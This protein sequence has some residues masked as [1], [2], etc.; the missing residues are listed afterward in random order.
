[1]ET[2]NIL[3]LLQATDYLRILKAST[4]FEPSRIRRGERSGSHV[5]FD[6]L[7]NKIGLDGIQRIMGEEWLDKADNIFTSWSI[8]DAE[9]FLNTL[10][11]Q[12]IPIYNIVT[13]LRITVNY[14]H[15]LKNNEINIVLEEMTSESQAESHQ[16]NEEATVEPSAEVSQVDEQIGSQIE[17]PQ[18]NENEELIETSPT[19]TSQTNEEVSTKSQVETPQKENEEIVTEASTRASQGDE[20]TSTESQKETSQQESEEVVTEASTRASQGDEETST[21][22]QK[23]TSQ[24][25]K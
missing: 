6:F 9:N 3:K 4:H 20:E 25:R 19:E 7:D 10:H 11:Y 8:A 15:A 14:L 16:G 17:A 12:R 18:S 5:I 21:E 1:M 22:S 24:T 2:G 23:E 13:I